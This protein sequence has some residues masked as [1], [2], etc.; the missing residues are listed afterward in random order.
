[1]DAVGKLPTNGVD[2]PAGLMDMP[3]YRSHK[4]VWALEIASIEEAGFDSTTDENRIIVVHFAD[5]RY[6][7]KR[8]NLYGKPTPQAGWYLVAYADGYISFSPKEQFEEGNA[9]E[10]VTFK[11]RVI[12]EK[13]E[14]S[15]KLVKLTAFIGGDGFA[16]LPMQ[17]RNRLGLQ[18]RFMSQYEEVLSERIANF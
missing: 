10:P 2:V 11:D 12:A 18:Q 5:G 4:T 17:E 7:P 13:N 16:G 8:V 3:K 6:A 1:M 9:L 15:D 14:L